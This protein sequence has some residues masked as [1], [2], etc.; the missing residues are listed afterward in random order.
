MEGP[1]FGFL[2]G[3]VFL[4]SVTMD[5]A[6]LCIKRWIKVCDGALKYEHANNIL[7]PFAWN[8]SGSVTSDS[9][10]VSSPP[11]HRLVWAFYSGPLG[12]RFQI[13]MKKA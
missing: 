13:S 4:K 2:E 8:C 5:L 1:W 7:G 3:V 6:T 11:S 10:G 9:A 12:P